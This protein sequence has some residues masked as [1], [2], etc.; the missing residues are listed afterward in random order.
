MAFSRDTWSR[1]T[2]ALNTGVVGTQGGPAIFSYRSTADAQ[3]AIAGANYF[4]D[5][6]YDLSPG[7][8]LFAL[9]NVNAYKSY[10]VVAVDQAAGTIT[11]AVIVW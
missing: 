2:V 4:A 3:A 5:A 8:L 7:D 9:D 6:V 1:Q 11:T 10:R